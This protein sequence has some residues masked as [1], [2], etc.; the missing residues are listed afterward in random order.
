MSGQPK[1]VEI[2]RS[3]IDAVHYDAR[4]DAVNFPDGVYFAGT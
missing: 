4:T 1:V 3:A 2:Q